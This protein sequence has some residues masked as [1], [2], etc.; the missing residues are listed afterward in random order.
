LAGEKF[1]FGRKTGFHNRIWKMLEN[2]SVQVTTI[3]RRR[4]RPRLP[5]EA[6][7]RRVE[8]LRRAFQRSLN[9]RPTLIEKAAMLRAAALVARAEAAALDPTMPVA[10]LTKLV[11]IADRAVR[12]LR[13]EARTGPPRGLLRARRR[14]AEAEQAKAAPAARRRKAPAAQTTTKALDDDQ[15][16]D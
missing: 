10:E 6:Q 5:I 16:E 11:N 14:W 13:L 7:A 3:P 15:A 2:T 9:R 1:P 8:E 12:G 4:Q